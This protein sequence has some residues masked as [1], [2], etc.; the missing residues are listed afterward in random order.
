MK[1]DF[2]RIRGLAANCLQQAHELLEWVYLDNVCAEPAETVIKRLLPELRTTLIR[3]REVLGR[4]GESLARPDTPRFCGK[5]GRSHC[6][7]AYNWSRD[8]FADVLQAIDTKQGLDAA[9]DIAAEIDW[10]ALPE[11]T[12]ADIRAGLTMRLPNEADIGDRIAWADAEAIRAEHG[13]FAT[14]L[15]NTI[16]EPADAPNGSK[17]G[18]SK[19]TEVLKFVDEHKKSNAGATDA[20]AIAAWRK[21]HP[22]KHGDV[23]VSDIR[24]ARA[25]AKRRGVSNIT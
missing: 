9:D 22:I 2:D 13:E 17:A 8:V 6:E 12:V 21:K 4:I 11:F 14:Q 23:K 15:R 16:H 7:V 25:D 18:K 5:S 19:Y 1:S 24:Q 10:S 3:T 20:T